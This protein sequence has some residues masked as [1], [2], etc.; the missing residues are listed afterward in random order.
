MHRMSHEIEGGQSMKWFL[1]VSVAAAFLA[2]S[3]LGAGRVIAGPTQ[4][5]VFGTGALPDGT[6]DFNSAF[7]FNA[8]NS[9]TTGSANVAVGESA[10]K[11]NT[12]GFENTA[13]GELALF[14]N[15]T[16]F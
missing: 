11:T 14:F 5:T 7:G 16:G 4:N 8:L 13:V 12:E 15:T 1:C 10:L 9:N 6:G 2:A 3:L